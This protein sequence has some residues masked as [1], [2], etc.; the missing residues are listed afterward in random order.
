VGNLVRDNDREFVVARREPEHSG[1]NPDLSASHCEG[2]DLGFFEKDELPAGI[3]YVPKDDFGDPGADPLKPLIVGGVGGDLLGGFHFGEGFHAHFCHGLV[4][5]EVETLSSS[6]RDGGATNDSENGGE[7][8]SG[9]GESLECA[10][11]GENLLEVESNLGQ[12]MQPNGSDKSGREFAPRGPVR[13]FAPTRNPRYS[14]N[15]HQSRRVQISGSKPGI[16]TLLV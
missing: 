11:V 9:D 14:R 4:I 16:C 12:S 1:V 6:D 13:D 15:H 10:H 5:N 2:V 3:R 8:K 7:R